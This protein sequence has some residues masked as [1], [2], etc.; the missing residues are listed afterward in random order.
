MDRGRL[1]NELGIPLLALR[2]KRRHELEQ[3]Q[4]KCGSRFELPKLLRGSVMG[5]SAERRSKCVCEKGL[6][7]V[8]AQLRW[9]GN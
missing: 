4:A 1:D 8:V 2:R 6:P 7:L 9:N 5:L 3:V